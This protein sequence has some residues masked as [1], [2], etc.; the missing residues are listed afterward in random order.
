MVIRTPCGADFDKMDPRGTARFCGSCEKLVHDLSAMSERKARALLST[1]SEALC[2]RY[3]HDATGEIWFAPERRPLI[4]GDRLARGKRGLAAAALLAA[5]P[6]LFQACGGA[7][8]GGYGPYRDGDAAAPDDND[9]AEAEASDGGTERSA[10]RDETPD[11]APAPAPPAIEPAM[12]GEA[13]QS[14]DPD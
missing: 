8:N 10:V 14:G 2:V 13:G 11:P 3:L 7:D 5:A 4:G 1:S 9:G 6:A 12:N